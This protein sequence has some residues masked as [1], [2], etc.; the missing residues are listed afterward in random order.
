MD[1]IV[2]TLVS[3]LLAVIA[4]SGFWTFMQKRADKKGRKD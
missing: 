2:Q 3:V 1:P 4:S